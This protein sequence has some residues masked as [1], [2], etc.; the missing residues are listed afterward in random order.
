MK[1]MQK[2]LNDDQL[3][4]LQ[5]DDPSKNTRE[6]NDETIKVALQIRIVVGARGYEFLRK[7][8]GWP[9]PSLRT[10]C[11]RLEVLQFIPG[12]TEGIVEF[13]QIK[14]LIPMTQLLPCAS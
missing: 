10:L 12:E 11:R 9:L 3:T 14:L 1:N 2:F 5:L 4:L 13:C 8:L 6:W 7:K